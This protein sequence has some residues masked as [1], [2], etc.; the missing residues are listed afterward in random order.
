MLSFKFLNKL[1]LVQYDTRIC[2][3]NIWKYPTVARNASWAYDIIIFTITF[4]T[5]ETLIIYEFTKLR[6]ASI[7]GNKC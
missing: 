6:N 2:E 4:F 5:S 3:K 1:R 7:N